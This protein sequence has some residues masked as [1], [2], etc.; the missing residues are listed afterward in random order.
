MDINKQ[1]LLGAFVGLVV[2]IGGLYYTRSTP[3]VPAAPAPLGALTGPDVPYDH[4]SWGLGLGSVVYPVRS[5][6]VLSTTTPFS[7]MSP[8]ATSTIDSFACTTSTATS[9]AQSFILTKGL[10][11]QS[12]TTALSNTISLAA[13]ATASIVASSTPDI[14]RVIAPSNFVQ[15]NAIGGTGFS[16]LSGFCTVV[17]RVI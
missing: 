15:F 10:G 5:A 17:F 12:S 14:T 3:S 4:L 2:L 8:A 1:G 6:L 7:A 16:N 11:M 13:G 9:T